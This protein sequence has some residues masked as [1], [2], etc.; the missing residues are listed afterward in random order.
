MINTQFG[1]GWSGEYWRT[2]DRYNFPEKVDSAK[3]SNMGC[4]LLKKNK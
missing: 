1:K 4:F 2:G 3:E